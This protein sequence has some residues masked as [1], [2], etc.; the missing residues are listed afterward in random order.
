MYRVVV[1]SLVLGFE[2]SLFME[3]TPLLRRVTDIAHV[4]PHPNPI[5]DGVLQEPGE[6]DKIF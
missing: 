1:V 4:G 3:E 2:H 6:V 5:E